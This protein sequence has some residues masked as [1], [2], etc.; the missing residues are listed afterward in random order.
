RQR[1][2]FD[3]HAFKSN[4]RQECARMP[5]E[6]G[7]IRHSNAART[8]WN[9]GS[10]PHRASA[11]HPVQETAI[12]PV[13]SGLIRGT[14]ANLGH[15][16]SAGPR[17]TLCRPDRTGNPR[18][19]HHQRGRGQP[20]LSRLRRR[21]AREISVLG[22]G[23]RRDGGRGGAPPHHAVRPLPDEI[24]RIPA[25]DPPPGRQGLHSEEAAVAHAPA[26]SRRGAQ[27]R[28]EHGVRSGAILPA[29]HGHDARHLGAPAPGRTRRGRGGARKPGPQA[30][31]TN[32]DA[33]RAR[34]GG[35][36]RAAH[37]LAAIRAAGPRWTVSTLAPLFAAA[38]ATH[39]TWET[40]LV[41][42][43]ASVGAGI[44]MGFAEALS[45]D[46]SLT[47]RGAPL[48][49]GAVCGMMT[50]IGGLGHTLPYLIPN[51]WTATAVAIAVVAVELVAI[52]YIRHRFM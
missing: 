29:R 22:Q 33:Q 27:V 43:A 5:R 19:C 15:L 38:F 20:Y 17:E 26:Q 37:V 34:Q 4:R 16:R 39:N 9:A 30:R 25:A 36:N 41:G 10:H 14:P 40:F 46:G 3:G 51:F 31:P 32:L 44:A 28:R 8:A 1:E 49:R 7:Q 11:L 18:A 23:L 2:T 42:L 13:C 6:N 35:R 24:R 21:A 52:S 47:G 12:I 48:V 45:D 50:A